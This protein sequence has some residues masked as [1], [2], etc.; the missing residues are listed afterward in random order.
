MKRKL[1]KT[2]K[3]LLTKPFDPFKSQPSIII[4]L[5]HVGH[6]CINCGIWVLPRLWK[7]GVVVIFPSKQYRI[8]CDG[9]RNLLGYSNHLCQ[10]SEDNICFIEHIDHLCDCENE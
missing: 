6:N 1:T 2:L 10:Y 3:T 9:C 8:L 5:L 7:N 4:E